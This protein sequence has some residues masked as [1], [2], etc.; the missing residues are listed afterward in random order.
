MVKLNDLIDWGRAYE[1]VEKAFPILETRLREL[2]NLESV[3]AYAEL[4]DRPPRISVQFVPRGSV[5]SPNSSEPQ[6][7]PLTADQERELKKKADYIGET[8]AQIA[9]DLNLKITPGCDNLH[10]MPAPIGYTI[11]PD[12][13][14]FR[15]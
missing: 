4:E 12:Y 15:R 10:F 3:Q 9:T 1:Q 11:K 13:S 2:L 8:L 5:N 6:A 7:M 14:Q